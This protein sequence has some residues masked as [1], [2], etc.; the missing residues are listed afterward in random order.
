MVEIRLLGPPEVWVE[1]RRLELPT[2]K[3]LALLAYLLLEGP[4][5]RARLA[6]LLWEGFDRRARANLRSELYRLKQTPLAAVLREEGG[7]LCLEGVESDLRRFEQHAARGEWALA[8]A[9]RRDVL[10]EGLELPEAPLFEEWLLLTREAWEERYRRA[11][12]RHAEGLE[13]AGQARAALEAYQQFLRLDPLGE[14]A[15]RAVMRLFERLGE[16]GLALE[17]Y[18]RFAA[19]L[20][21]ELG[22]PPARETRQLAERIRTGGTSP[23]LPPGPAA[24]RAQARVGSARAG[25]GGWPCGVRDRRAGGGQDP[26]Y[27]GVHRPA[28]AK[29]AL[30]HRTARRRRGSLR[31]RHP[32]AAPPGRAP[33]A[34][35]P[36]GLGSPRTQPAFTRAGRA[37]PADALGGGAAAAV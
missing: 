22:L 12:F 27:P 26:A 28:R 15:L 6:E 2:R 3:L 9:L 21:R 18:A 35:G 23:A 34:G 10:L 36:R 4:T 37:A 30:R 25:L 33:A 14:E 24:G 1:G 13:R 19:F 16:P 29:A 17:S 20:E 31:H 5:P 8:L 32:P 7:C 11:L